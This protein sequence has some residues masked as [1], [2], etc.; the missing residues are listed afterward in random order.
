MGAQ[1]R[2]SSSPLILLPR[3]STSSK[4]SGSGSSKVVSGAIGS[5]RSRGS[6]CTTRRRL[7]VAKGVVSCAGRQLVPAKECPSSAA[8]G[9]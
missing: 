5:G 3:S 9:Q 1:Y 4:S 8:S 7:A 6:R 2:G